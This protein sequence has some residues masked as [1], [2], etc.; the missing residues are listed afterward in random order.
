M[1]FFKN[2][3][4]FA[5]QVI[6]NFSN[7][8][9]LTEDQKVQRKFRIPDTERVFS[10]V[11]CLVSFV[12]SDKRDISLSAKAESSHRLQ[13]TTSYLVYDDTG[14][15]RVVLHLAGITELKK[16]FWSECIIIQIKTIHGWKMVMRID[17]LRSTAEK[18][19]LQFEKHWTSNKLK[20]DKLIEFTKDSFSEWLTTESQVK[21]HRSLHDLP[22]GL[23]LAHRFPGYMDKEM[24]RQFLKHWYNYFKVA[25]RNLSL[26]QTH[27]FKK[28]IA[29]CMANELRS[30]IWELTSGSI[31]YRFENEGEYK[32]L[33]DFNKN[34]T[35][36]AIDDIEKDLNR[37]LPE[38]AAYQ[39]PEGIDK[40]RR[41]LTAYSWKVPE[42]G[43]CQG[44]NILTAALLIFMDE[45]QAFWTLYVICERLVPGYYTK[46]MYGAL[47]DQRV[48][49][50]LIN[51]HMPLLGQHFEKNDIK[52]SIISLPWFLSFFLNTI[53]LVFA[54]SIMDSFF[55]NGVKSLFHYSLA[56]V[57]INSD[58]L[59]ECSDIGEAIAVLKEYF[60]TLD[61]HDAYLSGQKTKFDILKQVAEKD[62]GSI[63][64]TDI[65]RERIRNEDEVILYINEFV[66]RTEMRN[67]PKDLVKNLNQKQIS[68]IYDLYY[69]VLTEG[70]KKQPND[71]GGV[72]T[73]ADFKLFMSKLVPWVNLNYQN[74]ELHSQ[75]SFLRR[76]YKH[77][78]RE[79]VM[80]FE[81]LCTGLNKFVDRD[82]MRLIT[83]FFE[84][85]DDEGT[86][87]LPKSHIMQIADDLIY[88][89]T[90]WRTGALFDQITNKMLE[91]R[92]AQ[93]LI[94]RQQKMKEQGLTENEEPNNIPTNLSYDRE[95][96]EKLQADRY[97]SSSSNFLKLSFQYAIPKE[98]EEEDV[99][100]IEIDKSHHR[101][102]EA[103]KHNKAL[104]PSH[105]LYINEST[106]RMVIVTDETYSSFFDNELW[107]SF[108]VNEET[109][110]AS[111]NGMIS[112]LRGAVNVVMTSGQR[113]ATEV[114]RQMDETRTRK[115]SIRSARS[116]GS[117]GTFSSVG[118]SMPPADTFK[119]LQEPTK[120]QTAATNDSTEEDGEDHEIGF[121]SPTKS[122]DKSLNFDDTEI[123]EMID[124]EGGGDEDDD[125]GNFVPAAKVE[126]KEPA[127]DKLVT[128]L[129]DL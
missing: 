49:E 33:L 53:P 114:K 26:V 95:K 85:Y 44:M 17:E 65:I 38:Y 21:G 100:L 67:I 25:G 22:G 90:P 9:D 127:L 29:K 37:S 62:F 6:D 105:Q 124:S 97:L 117:V 24:R 10:S 103:I 7:P 91:Q 61:E 14:D 123:N 18:F 15:D 129:I 106:F 84:L 69:K 11:D 27:V 64:E 98:E 30:D 76:L 58:K 126:P 4:G 71:G 23:G 32:M 86:G 72:L 79:G 51:K 110:M 42:V 83:A 109:E 121:L 40:L 36:A 77:W 1:S 12:G 120:P 118:A 28:M 108:R 2:V 80:T 39:T 112:N 31:Y 19:Y 8:E 125:F 16:A 57:K 111:N 78:S 81:T 119:Q 93:V 89:T 102:L 107:S 3:V 47:L 70:H 54:F 13:L 45:E 52:I 66:K 43:Y 35:S 115:D 60:S 99:N 50:E 20:Q 46:T 56:I 87:M 73:M 104:D 74:N 88:I 48:L 68:N 101:E 96:Y 5:Q 63:K 82:G 128:S 116:L 122:P 41:V 34:N 75:N 94:R 59:M 55:V 113:V 92:I